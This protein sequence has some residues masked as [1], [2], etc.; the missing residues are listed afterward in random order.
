MQH[1]FIH[2]REARSA[3]A[4]LP[5]LEDDPISSSDPIF[6]E[7]SSEAIPALEQELNDES[8]KCKKDW[9]TYNGGDATGEVER[10]SYKKP[11]FFD[12][13]LNYAELNMERLQERAGEGRRQGAA[14]GYLAGEVLTRAQQGREAR[15]MGRGV[16]VGGE[17]GDD[18]HGRQLR[19]RHLPF[20]VGQGTAPEQLAHCQPPVVQNGRG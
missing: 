4:L 14:Q 7:L 19:H 11:L 1:A 17:M 13:A 12:I 2:L 8:L 6:Y 3:Q 9:F 5:S 16:E 20:G 18:T 15:P 10:Q